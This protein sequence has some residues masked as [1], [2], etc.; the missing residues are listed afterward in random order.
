MKHTWRLNERHYG[1]LTG[2]SKTEAAAQLGDEMLLRYRRGYDTE[3]LA[4][5]SEHE[6]ERERERETGIQRKQSLVHV[7]I[8]TKNSNRK[9]R[10]CT[11]TCC[12]RRP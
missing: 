7:G 11:R 3:P 6:R 4:M 1:M 10:W 2:L 12:W 9:K 5:V 8:H